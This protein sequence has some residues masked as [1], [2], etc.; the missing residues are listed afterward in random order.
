LKN[1]DL[2]TVRS[3]IGRFDNAVTLRGNVAYPGRLPWKQGLRVRDLIPDRAALI[4]RD[5]WLRQN[6]AI[7]RADRSISPSE[8]SMVD[9]PFEGQPSGAAAD[10]MN[11]RGKNADGRS[12]QDSSLTVEKQLAARDLQTKEEIKNDIALSDADINW[13]Y[14]VIQRLNKDDLSTSLLPFNLGKAL[15]G[16]PE[17]NVLLEP[18]DVLS[19]FSLSDI[20]VSSSKKS[21]FVRLEGEFRTAGVYEAKPGETLRSMV[22]RAGGLTS[23]AYLYASQFT[24]NS[25][26][27]AQQKELDDYITQ[28]DRELEATASQASQNLLNPEDAA[29][30]AAKI[31]AQRRLME[32]LRQVRTTGRIVLDLKPDDKDSAAIPDLPLRRWRQVRHS[33]SPGNGKCGWRCLS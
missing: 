23:S 4:T 25:V 9:V 32:K 7:T 27:L 19:I 22:E 6:H 21:V 33:I 30:L 14:A 3:L 28:A 31:E 8:L 1:G 5:Y 11:R 24:R 12:R 20:K 17:N 2:V 13:D 26:R 16:D 15:N 10:D 29:G 18:G